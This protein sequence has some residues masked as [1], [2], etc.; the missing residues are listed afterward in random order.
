[1]TKD[2]MME[3]SIRK[4]MVTLKVDFLSQIKYLLST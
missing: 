2:F 4:K 1:M 3:I